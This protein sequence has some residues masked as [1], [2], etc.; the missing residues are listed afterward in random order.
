MRSDSRLSLLYRIPLRLLLG[1]VLF[2]ALVAVVN[3]S[4]APFY[5]FP[6]S[7]P[8]SGSRWNNPYASIDSNAWLKGNFQ[9]QSR[10]WGGLTNGRRND[11]ESIYKVYQEVGYD[12]VGI[13]DYMHVNTWARD[14]ATWLPMYEHGYGLRKNHQVCLGTSKVSWADY[15]YPQHI[16]QKQHILDLLRPHNAVVAIAHPRLMDAYRPDDMRRLSGY[17]CIEVLNTFRESIPHWDAALSA[18]R[19][20]YIL[21]NDDAHDISK[22]HEVARYCTMVNAPALGD[23]IMEAIRLG[24]AFGARLPNWEGMSFKEK[25]QRHHVMPRLLSVTIINDSLRV[26]FSRPAVLRFIG[27][28]GV[29]KALTDSLSSG[30]YALQPE[31]TYIRVEASFEDGTHFFLNPVYR[32]SDS[33][34]SSQE[35]SLRPW[36]TWGL[37]ILGTLAFLALLILGIKVIRRI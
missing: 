18:G 2:L 35:A 29:V 19:P 21:A 6:E 24:Q 33:G 9:V 17:D 25:A 12:I 32:I 20:A 28:E 10:V 7:R 30:T 37:R 23:S 3:Y 1:L 34:P 22:P 14:S 13:S 26:H 11:A 5:T 16:H 8:F 27:Q 15:P 31:D 4:A 36:P